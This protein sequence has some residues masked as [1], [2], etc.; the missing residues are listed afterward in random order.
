[1]PFFK[2][3]ITES[4]KRV[5]IIEADSKD[6]VTKDFRATTF[7]NRGSALMGVIDNSLSNHCLI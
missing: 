1:M 2:V 5:V 4:L 7:F 6:E 3:E